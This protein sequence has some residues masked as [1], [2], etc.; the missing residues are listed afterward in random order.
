MIDFHSHILPGIDDG[1]KD[2][3]QSM[4]MLRACAARCFASALT[5]EKACGKFLIIC[6]SP[7]MSFHGRRTSK[8]PHAGNRA[9]FDKKIL[10]LATILMEGIGGANP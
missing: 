8:Q 4:D 9:F 1:A 10:Q 2:P 7:E 3:E 5:Q 6:A